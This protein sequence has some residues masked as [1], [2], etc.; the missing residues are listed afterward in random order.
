[1]KL[2]T[3]SGAPNPRKV[4]IYLT[5]KRLELETVTVSA[6]GSRHRARDLVA[7]HPMAAV[8]VLELDDGQSLSVP[9]AIIEYLEELYPD[10][11]LI[12]HDPWTRAVT[13]EVTAIA[14]RG[15]LDAA[16]IASEHSSPEFRGH[17]D[18]SP[19]LAAAVRSRFTRA[20]RLF[21]DLLLHHEWLAGP[22]FTIADITAF[23]AI[24]HGEDCG[25]AVPTDAVRMRNWLERMGARPSTRY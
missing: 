16:L 9:D 23:V 10:P 22:A 25:C 14:E 21:D 1:M 7:R 13:R 11:P 4:D 2:Y 17:V 15:L 5:E 12:G 20:I 6:P 3:F 19:A 18:Q 8:P 24:E